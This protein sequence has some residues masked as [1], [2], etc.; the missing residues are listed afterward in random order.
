MKLSVIIPSWNRRENILKT[1]SC[2]QKQTRL[3]DEVIVIDDGSTD[4]T[5]LA[6]LKETWSL[7]LKLLHRNTHQSWNASIPRNM[8]ARLTTID[9]DAFLFLDSD[10]LLPPDRIE[11]F[12][13]DYEQNP[14]ENRVIIGPYHYMQSPLNLRD[15]WFQ[16]SITNYNADAR[17]ESFQ[18]HPVEEI[19]TGI[20]FALACF[21]GSLF[22]PRKFFFKAGGYDESV[23][24]G[25]EDGDFGITLWETGAVFSLD[26]NLLGWHH[27]HEI[28]P[29]RTANIKEMVDYINAKHKMDLVHET[30]KA[31]REWGIDWVVPEQWIVGSGYEREQL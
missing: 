1:L 2:L 18:Q 5:S 19:N 26:K 6:I 22:I 14:L 8:G 31:M 21:G 13:K 12:I 9:T 16:E 25:C 24:S 3:P 29:S 11:V 30:G 15:N 28:T 17:W 10:I 4:E 23:T 27:P 20:G 7:N